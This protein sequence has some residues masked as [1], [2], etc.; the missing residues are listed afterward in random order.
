MD[1]EDAG[2]NIKYLIRDQDCK[3][4]ALFDTILADASIRVVRS[5]VQIPQR[6]GEAGNNDFSYAPP[7]AAFADSTNTTVYVNGQFAS[8]LSGVS[9]RAC[10]VR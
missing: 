5:G 3:Y 1:I 2:R 6:C 4:P 9:S 8:Q 10:S 7:T